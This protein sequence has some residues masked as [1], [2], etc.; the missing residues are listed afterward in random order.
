MFLK[1]SNETFLEAAV[2]P[3]GITGLFADQVHPGLFTIF[4][5]S[6]YANISAVFIMFNLSKLGRLVKPYCDL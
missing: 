5:L 1:L 3:A 6:S 4:S 2:I